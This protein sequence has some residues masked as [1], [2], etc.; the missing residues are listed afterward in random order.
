MSDPEAG[1]V[2]RMLSVCFSILL[3]AMALYAAVEVVQSIWLQLCIGAF[4][5]VVVALA[6]WYFGIRAR[7]F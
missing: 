3:A 7:R 2:S 6:V 1:L 4:V 5:I